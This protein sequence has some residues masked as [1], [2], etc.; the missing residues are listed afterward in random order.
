MAVAVMIIALWWLVAHNAG[1]GWVQLLGDLVFG[2]LCIGIVGP[3]VVVTRARV[4]VRAAPAD[5][6]AGLPVDILV[7]SGTRVRVR[8]I[9]PPGPEIFV[10][11]VG[12]KRSVGDRIT[13]IPVRRGV[14]DRVTVDIAS[15]APFAL[16]WWTRRVQLPL[17]AEL[18]VSPRCGRPDRPRASPREEVGEVAD[19]PRTDAGFPRGARPY[20]P[21]D[22]RRLMHWRA[23]A[24]AGKL[25]VRELERPSADA[26]TVTV[27]L[28]D[29]P[30]EAERVAERALGTVVHLLDAGTPVLIGTVEP[31]GPVVAPVADRRSAGRRLAR[32]VARGEG[33]TSTGGGP[34][35]T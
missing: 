32:A 1:A 26:V 17:P 7:E 31:A 19:R 6:I 13:L 15:A 30:E 23:T 16:Q 21:G 5:A 33:S 25:M 35:A 22:G 18:H 34:G 8:A 11:P 2:T 20:A 24:H 4:E 9:E 27:E 14:Y 3:W 28:P 10:G 12:R 29:D